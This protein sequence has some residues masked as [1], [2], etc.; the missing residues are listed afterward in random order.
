MPSYLPILGG[1]FNCWINPKLDRSS[2]R[3]VPTS[4]SAKAI[5]SFMEEFSMSDPWCL[6]NDSGRR[7]FLFFPNVHHTLTWIDYFL[8]D[9][10]LLSSV[11]SCSYDAIVI[12]D[13][14][15]VILEIQF[16][17]YSVARPAWR[18]NTRLLSNEN[19]VSFISTNRP[20]SVAK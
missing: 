2:T 12:S 11:H 3:N 17:D 10:R 6:F 9:N 5:Q 13:H 20:F 14:A 19:F 8:L 7:I 1:D 16:E 18:L 4:K 15:P